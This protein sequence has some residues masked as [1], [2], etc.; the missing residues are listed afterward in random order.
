MKKFLSRSI[1]TILF[2]FFLSVMF[3][4]I[5]GK[6]ESISPNPE[7]LNKPTEKEIISLNSGENSPWILYFGVQDEKAPRSPR[8]L[9]RSGFSRIPATVPGNV[10]IDLQSAGIIEDPMIGDH[11]YDMRK[12]E[13]YQWWYH[14]SFGKP[15]VAQGERIELSLEGIDCIADVWLNDVKIARVENMFVEHHFDITDLVGENNELYICIHSTVLEARKHLRNNFGV[16]YDAL[17]EAV[18]VRKAP[19]MFGWD[20]MPRLVSAGLWREVNLEIIP[21]THWKSVYWVTKNVDVEGRKASL[22]V[23]WEFGTDRLDIDNLVMEIRLEREGRIA[24]RKSVKIYTTVSRERIDGLENME[25]W[26]PR[27]S[28]DPALYEAS[29]VLMDDQGRVLCENRQQIGVRTVELVRSEMNTPENPGEFVFVVN[30]EKVFIKGTN[31]VPLDALHSRDI[32]HVDG[33]MDM[34]ADLNCNMVRLWGGNVYESD[35]FYDLCDRNGIMVWQDF[36]MGCTTYP[37]DLEFAEKVR[38]EAEKAIRRLRNHPAIVLWAGNNENDVSLNWSDDQSHMDPNTDIISRRVLPLA[39]REYDPKTPYLPSSPFISSEVFRLSNRIDPDASPEMHLWG[40]RG[41][42]KAPFYTANRAKFVSEIGYHGC[43]SRE[44][45]ERMMEPGFVYPWKEGF[46]WNKQ[47]QAKAVMSHPYAETSRDRNNLMINQVKELFG[48]VPTDL[49]T[50]IAASQVVQAE[51]MKYFIEF[52]RMN[53]FD[54]NGILWWNLRDGWPVISDAIVDYYGNKKLA[55][56][57]IKK[58]QTD[59]CVMIG[60]EQ[61]VKDAPGTGHPIVVVNDTR[62]PVSGKLTIRDAE[63]EKLVFSGSFQVEKNGKLVKGYLPNPA[64]TTL[65]L[66]EWELNGEVYSN[67]YLAFTPPVDL[68]QYLN[69]KIN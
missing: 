11:V 51:A 35:R 5:S 17:A 58:V 43:P 24:Y 29:L 63:S 7:V 54:R 32:Q 65:W 62:E 38:V 37:Q 19:H 36:T 41:Y 57:Y 48:E 20:I 3:S 8:G 60:D 39:V 42:Y 21:A 64:K 46:Q 2:P 27:G 69:Y 49:D 28:G 25:F 9:K 6:Q 47:W 31:W 10:E 61:L 22:Y 16:R 66:I 34:L 59:V 50:F 53:K 15:D 55:Y 52:W 40:P 13:T 33:A 14:R 56:R 1:R 23:D 67:H 68:E 44:S 18:S 45:L 26:W 4:C 12:Y 30:G